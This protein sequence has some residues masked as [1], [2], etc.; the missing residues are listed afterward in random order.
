MAQQTNYKNIAFIALQTATRVGYANDNENDDL[1]LAAATSGRYEED[2]KIQ[3]T[4][5]TKEEI[6]TKKLPEI[7]VFCYPKHK[8]LATKD[9]SEKF[10]INLATG[11]C[12][13]YTYKPTKD[14]KMFQDIK[15]WI[16][17]Y[18][19]NPNEQAVLF[20]SGKYAEW[21][22]ALPTFANVFIILAGGGYNPKEL[23][24]E[25]MVEI[26][27]KSGSQPR[28][29]IDHNHQ[30][31]LE[32]EDWNRSHK[33]NIDKLPHF[34]NI[35]LKELDKFGRAGWEALLRIP[36]LADTLMDFVYTDNF[37]RDELDKVG[38]VEK[39]N[40]KLKGL[41][42]FDLKNLE[43]DRAR[44][45]IERLFKHIPLCTREDIQHKTPAGLRFQG[46]Y[47]TARSVMRDLL[48]DLWPDRTWQ[49]KFFSLR[50]GLGEELLNCDPNMVWGDC[51]I[52]LSLSKKHQAKFK[53]SQRTFKRN[54]KGFVS[55]IKDENPVGNFYTLEFL[56]DEPLNVRAEMYGR[57]AMEWWTNF[58]VNWA[59]KVKH[60]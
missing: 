58:L 2:E 17:R 47:C 11:E 40:D 4:E 5:E 34:R 53:P 9:L 55:A 54:E 12:H 26:A 1:I 7:D 27:T 8:N 56:P 21:F 33:M 18:G 45:V 20:I 6:L 41:R 51:A 16:E 24:D 14:G 46:S 36:E 48:S 42:H 3:N 19:V 29:Y 35:T 60:D 25:E 28:F 31:N 37:S 44:Y 50:S 30:L 57:I 59:S 13:F 23:K 52:A 49:S 22:A 32:V 10:W 39:F 38:T 15:N 43:V